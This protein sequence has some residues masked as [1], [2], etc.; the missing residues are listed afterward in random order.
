MT[1]D[2]IR[3]K[4]RETQKLVSTSKTS[5]GKYGNAHIIYDMND[6]LIADRHHSGSGTNSRTKRRREGPG[7]IQSGRR[8][9]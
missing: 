3:H 2:N 7:E 1:T 6:G 9:C 4:R 5:R 8:A